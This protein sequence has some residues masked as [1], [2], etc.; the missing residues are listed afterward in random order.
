MDSIRFNLPDQNSFPPTDIAKQNFDLEGF[1]WKDDYLHL[2][3]KSRLGG[4]NFTTKH[5]RISA[6]KRV[7]TAEILE[8]KFLDTVADAVKQSENVS[9][10]LEVALANSSMVPQYSVSD[11]DDLVCEYWNEFWSK[12]A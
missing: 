11:I 6:N 8:D 2:F 7:Q 3:S 5:Y 10:A 1:F 4:G 9:E 12:Y